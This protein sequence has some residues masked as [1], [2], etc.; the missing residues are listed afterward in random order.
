MDMDAIPHD[1]TGS[2]LGQRLRLARLQQGLSEHAL[3]QPEFTGNYVQALEQG[4]AHPSPQAL[5]VLA[6]RLRLHLPD[7]LPLTAPM[8]PDPDHAALEEDLAYQ[9]DHARILIFTQQGY[10]ALRLM[11]TAE[12]VYQPYLALFCAAIRCRFHRLRGRAYLRVA[13][14]ALA[15]TDLLLALALAEQLNDGQEIVRA[16]NAL[17]EACFQ[18][19]R[20]AA[21]REFHVQ[22]VHAI[23]I[24]TI[25]DLSLRLSIYTNLANDYWALNELT[26]AIGMYQEALRL[27]PDI[28]QAEGAARI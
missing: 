15:R 28:N 27:L 6:R 8:P 20:A 18:E 9:L 2:A 14:S 5:A 23:H 13:D 24:G 17:G 22:C 3:A 16:Q 19:G 12:E 10:A 1:A 21:A 4:R 26:P 11:N 25:R 7:L